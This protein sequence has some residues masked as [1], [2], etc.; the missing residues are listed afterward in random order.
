MFSHDELRTKLQEFLEA[1]TEAEQDALAREI[2]ANVIDPGWTD[3]VFYSSDH[4]REDG[5]VDYDLLA[6][7]TLSYKVIRL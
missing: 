3:R 2:G 4:N 5:S 1:P 6:E 7:K